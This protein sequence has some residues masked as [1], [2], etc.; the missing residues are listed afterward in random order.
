TTNLPTITSTG[1]ASPA[2][3]TSFVNGPLAKAGATAFTFPVGKAG[4]GFRNIGITTPSATATFRAEFFRVSPPA[5]TLEPTL[6]R[7]SACEYWDL[8]KTAGASGVSA[9][10]VLSWEANSNC[11]GAYVTNPVTLRV[12]HLLSGVWVDEGRLSSTGDATK[13]TITSADS[14][15][16]F[17]PFALASGS[18][19][20]NPLPVVFADVKAYGKN[21]GVQIE[22]SNLTE[23]DIASYSI[24]RSSNGRDFASIDQQSPTGNQSIKAEYNAFDANPNTGAN[25]YRIKAVETSGKIVYSKILTINL[26]R[27]NHGLELYP[28]PVLDHQVTISLSNLNKGQYTI[29]VINTAG[30]NIFRQIITNRGST[31]TQSLNLPATIKP[32]VYHMVITGD[33]YRENK[34]FIVR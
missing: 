14:P 27:E 25:F 5:G 12:A 11:G 29:R 1:T 24:E 8:S 16:T 22:W 18:A 28:N 17:S 23:Q 30:Q 31:L 26:G 21:N 9:N 33:G 6:T 2:T 10:V 19:A 13:G 15:T 34:M 4:F 32:G 20:D 3:L 7:V